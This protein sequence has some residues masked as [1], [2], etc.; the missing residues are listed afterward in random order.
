MEIGMA[1]G[2]DTVAQEAAVSGKWGDL[3]ADRGF[4]Q[5]PNYL[6]LLNQ[7]LD[8]EHKL[9][10]IELLVLLQIVGTW[11][12]KSDLPFP[13]MATLA[14][15]CGVSERQVQR[16]VARLEKGKFL[17]R[18]KRRNAGIVASNAYDLSPLVEILETV[19]RAFPNAY[20]RRAYRRG[21]AGAASHPSPED[22]AALDE[23]LKSIDAFAVRKTVSDDG[24]AVQSVDL[25]QAKALPKP[26]GSKRKLIVRPTN[27]P[28]S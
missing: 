22:L 5:I 4:A 3:I 7:F 18:V 11:W 2:S 20:P 9:S 17:K 14:D 12:R 8:A 27:K 6:L 26:Q 15:R 24:E 10:A 13:S 25:I 23:I 1:T 19:A 28:K 21:S 16:A